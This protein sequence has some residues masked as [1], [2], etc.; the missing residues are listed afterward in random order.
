MA[1]KAK[2]PHIRIDERIWDDPVILNLS[3][4]AF[5]TY[6]FSIAWSKSQGGRTPDGLLTEHG[7]TRICADPK[8]LDELVLN[9]LLEKGEDG[10]KILKYEE[11]QMTYEE[12]REVAAKAEV[13]REAGRQSAIKRWHDWSMSP[14]EEGFDFE[15]AFA[16][17]WDVWPG[18][19][20]SKFQESRNLAFESFQDN[21]T[22]SK[23]YEAFSQALM[24]RLRA[25]K[26][27]SEEKSRKRMFLGAFKNFC[28]KWQGWIPKTYRPATTE[29]LLQEGMAKLADD[30]V[31]Q[32]AM[33][34]VNNPAPKAVKPL[35]ASSWCPP[36]LLLD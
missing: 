14:P 6:I 16:A 29:N 22:N 34:S 26:S 9:S 11:W 15:K 23:D 13:K 19:S 4:G 25:Y 17:A 28:T 31:A 8:E 24:S 7:I 32:K 33:G 20:D 21:I 1:L 36:D 12:E 3:L 5:R 27:S 10:Y 35:P 18:P 2:Q 30:P